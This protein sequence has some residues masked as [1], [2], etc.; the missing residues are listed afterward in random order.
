MNSPLQASLA[1]GRP[2]SVSLPQEPG[3]LVTTWKR[4]VQRARDSCKPEASLPLQ[5]CNPEQY[6]AK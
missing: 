4:K 1:Q 2:G 5:A 3:Y 6:G